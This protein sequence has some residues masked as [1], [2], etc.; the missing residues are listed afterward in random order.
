M[1]K[2]T[3]KDKTL[4]VPAGLGNFGQSSGSGGGVT[5]EEAAQIASAVTAEALEEYD[6]ELQVDLEEI[7]EAVSANTGTLLDLSQIAVMTVA[8]RVALF[9]EIYEKAAS[10]EKVYIK[11]LVQEETIRTAILPLVS[12]RPETNPILHQGGYLYFAAKGDTDNIYFHVALSSEG[13]IDPTSSTFIKRNIYTLP[14]ASSEVKGGVKV[15]SGLLMTQDTL[16]LD[17]TGIVTDG[18]L[19]PFIVQLSGNTQDIATLS[20]V[21]E[22]M[23]QQIGSLSG[24]TDDIAA[25]SGQTTANTQ[26]I[27]ILSGDV[28]TNALA[29]ANLE[30]NVVPDLQDAI[31][32]AGNLANSANTK[33]DALSAVTSG[34]A[35]DIE[36][37]AESDNTVF[38]NL[39]EDYGTSWDEVAR[40]YD[41]IVDA[42]NTGKTAVLISCFKDD[43]VRTG[44]F[45]YCYK[46]EGQNRIYAN[47]AGQYFYN[48][49]NIAA[50]AAVTLYRNDYYN[51][52]VV[53]GHFRYDPI[54]TIEGYTLPTASS[55]TKGGI[56]VGSGLTMSGEVMSI[57][58]GD[59]LGFSGDTLVVSGASSGPTNYYLND[60]S[61]QELADLYDMLAELTEYDNGS[62]N[63]PYIFENYRFFAH[64]ADVDG[65]QYVQLFFSNWEEQDGNY[66]LWIGGMLP[67][68]ASYPVSIHRTIAIILSD[69]TLQMSNSD[70]TNIDDAANDF[71]IPINSNGYINSSVLDNFSSLAKFNRFVFVY[72]DENIT[73]NY[74][75]AP[76]KYF[77]RKNETINGEDKLVE[78]IG[79][80]ININGTWYK[81][82]WHFAE[83]EWSE[84]NAPDTWTTI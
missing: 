72:Q 21:T 22:T 9:D 4:V 23:S 81:G 79:V 16:S 83:Y 6:T 64:T 77:Y 20:G 30:N 33:V 14:T 73:N 71:Q 43:S 26:D 31:T 7:R 17:T 29:I 28:E 19:A 55:S 41:D 54:G 56:K 24:L 49:K 34:L 44:C 61:Q 10:G 5:P 48:S 3:D 75:A 60:M 37:L 59:G 58:A 78:Y 18:D 47:G 39:L 8:D 82:D 51:L 25:V 74:C 1:I 35:V 13:A 15:G 52:T 50:R 76:L 69:G 68:K 36:T 45:A 40:L 32:A 12:Y 2:L 62:S 70:L 46:Y 27:G 84:W 11:G 57:K 42:L 63:I 80:E 66:Q 67:T 65:Q 38:F 53:N